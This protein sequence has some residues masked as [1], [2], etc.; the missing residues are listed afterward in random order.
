MWVGENDAAMLN[1]LTTEG[2]GAG[3]LGAASAAAAAKSPTPPG[4]YL[5]ALRSTYMVLQ[6]T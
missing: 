5:V 1:A 6:Y 3:P 4:R 2:R